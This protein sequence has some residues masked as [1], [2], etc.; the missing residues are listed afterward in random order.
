MEYLIFIIIIV[1]VGGVIGGLMGP[2]IESIDE[3]KAKKAGTISNLSGYIEINSFYTKVVGVTYGNIQNILPQL[4]I[5][6]PL[7]FFREPNNAYDKNAIRV[8]CNGNNIGHLSADIASELSPI[9]DRGGIVTGQIESIT[10]GGGK[11]YGCNISIK[12]YEK[13]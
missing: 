9:I 7:A 13:Q 11:S 12:V 1:V 6:T 5:G 2:I 8:E 4:Q 3:R 10:G